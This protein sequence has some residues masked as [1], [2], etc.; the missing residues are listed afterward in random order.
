MKSPTVATAKQLF[1]I[2]GNRCAFPKCTSP[3]IHD[4]KV[5]G[6]ICHLKGAKPGSTRYDANQS[7]EE[8]HSFQ[9]LILMCPIHHDVID[10]DEVAYPV[11][12]LLKLKADREAQAAKP[13]DLSD[14]EAQQ[15]LVL[16][17]APTTNQHFT[18]VYNQNVSSTNQSGGITAHTI[19]FQKPLRTM[20]DG[21]KKTI[22]EQCPRDKMIVVW[23]IAGD[24]E[25]HSFAKEIFDFM[26]SNGFK[27]FGDGPTGNIFFKPLKG[28]MF[29]PGDTCNNVYVGFPDGSERV[30]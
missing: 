19:S 18:N 11:E 30:A 5:T 9:N 12:R 22:L 17:F 29:T 6:R 3:L 24:E 4:G 10:D 15:F 2:S 23:S 8:R 20:G 1:A 13:L 25:S 16:L 14:S 7:D 26:R 27:L 21:M 28:V